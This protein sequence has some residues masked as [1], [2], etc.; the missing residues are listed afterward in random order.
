MSKIL[1][2]VL[3]I[4]LIALAAAHTARAQVP[5][6][7]NP[8][9]VTDVQNLRDSV[10]VLASRLADIDDKVTAI[11]IPPT[12]ISTGMAFLPSGHAVLCAV[13]NVG[14]SPVTVTTELRTF[15]GALVESRSDVEL[16]ARIGAGIGGSKPVSVYWCRFEITS[17]SSADIRAHLNITDAASVELVT[18]EAR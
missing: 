7:G 8:T 2:T 6:Q 1:S 15:N 4:P 13:L 18:R 10:D 3:V 9:I 14:T 17:G 5:N 11:G 12:V 16:P